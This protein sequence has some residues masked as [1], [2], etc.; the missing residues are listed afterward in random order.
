MQSV[1]SAAS[2]AMSRLCTAASIGSS[3]STG[4]T[5]SLL[6]ETS[7]PGG[8]SNCVCCARLSK[9]F[10]A[11]CLSRSSR[12]IKTPDPTNIMIRTIVRQWITDFFFCDHTHSCQVFLFTRIISFFQ[13]PCNGTKLYRAGNQS[14]SHIGGECLIDELLQRL[15][16]LLFR[17]GAD[18]GLTH[19]VAAAVDHIG[20]GISKDVGSKL[21]RLTI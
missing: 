19:D 5:A 1:F 11:L 18:D 8:A 13:K 3:A 20:G 7:P 6:D 21:S 4:G 2:T 16:L 15:R 17:D 14:S 12:K 9:F 10:C